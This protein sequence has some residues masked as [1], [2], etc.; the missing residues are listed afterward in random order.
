VRLLLVVPAYPYAEYRSSGIFSQRSAIALAEA[1]ESVEVLVPRPYVP[2]QLARLSPRWTAYSRIPA[3]QQEGRLVVHRPAYLQIPGAASPLWAERAAYLASRRLVEARHESAGF[4]AILSFDLRGGAPVAWRLARHLGLPVAGWATGSDVRVGKPG[5]TARA[6][7][8]SLRNLDLVFYQSG[9]LRQ[10]AAGLLGTRV[11]GLDPRRHVVL[12]RGVAEP[13]AR[14]WRASRYATRDR[15]GVR[16]DETAVVTIGRISQ[17]KGID[18]LL[19][20]ASLLGAS[21][22]RVRF[23]LV[24]ARPG[25]DESDRVSNAIASDPVLRS[26]VQLLPACAPDEVWDYLAASDIFAFPS[27][28]EGM[29]NSPLEAMAMERPVVAFAIPP[30]QEIDGGKGIVDLC[31]PFDVAAFAESIRRLA[32][33]EDERLR[34]GA[35]GRAVVRERFLVRRSMAAAVE[36]L[37]EEV[38]GARGGAAG[39]RSVASA[40]RA[41]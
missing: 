13:P 15:L 2:P 30:V 29:P 20:A 39:L 41:G 32:I 18:D 1:C 6:A 36:R 24:G 21:T 37:R 34:R 12:P 16:E 28:A 5:A 27:H 40:G 33:G 14:D 8:R 11:G 31:P 38:R 26:R 35:E 3:S 25:F 19:A 7:A 10:I 23:V 22:G 4:D 9:E 17:A